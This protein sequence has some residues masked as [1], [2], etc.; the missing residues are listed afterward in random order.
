MPVWFSHE[1]LP[2]PDARMWIKWQ[3]AWLSGYSVAKFAAS[4]KHAEDSE[5]GTQ[6]I[7]FLK[8]WN[9]TEMKLC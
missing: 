6:L 8:L 5:A 1:I 4:D 9:R 7:R 3:I 2:Q